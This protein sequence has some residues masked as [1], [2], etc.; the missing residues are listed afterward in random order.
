ML[1]FVLLLQQ[2]GMLVEAK[3]LLVAEDETLLFSDQIH[4][5]SLTKFSAVA[6]SKNLTLASSGQQKINVFDTLDFAESS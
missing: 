5:S 3:S 6:S 4:L 1:A 2:M